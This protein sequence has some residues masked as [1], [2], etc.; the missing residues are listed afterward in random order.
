MHEDA[1]LAGYVYVDTANA[2]P[3]LLHDG[4]EAHTIGKLTISGQLERRAALM[5]APPLPSNGLPAQLDLKNAQRSARVSIEQEHERQPQHRQQ[6]QRAEVSQGT[7]GFCARTTHA[8]DS[9]S[10]RRSGAN[11]RE[12]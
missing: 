5:P 2:T 3:I 4:K 9:Q 12:K 8:G 11:F 1:Q 7:T 10:V 6:C